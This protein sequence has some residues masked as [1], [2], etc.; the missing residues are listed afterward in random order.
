MLD[1]GGLVA[2]VFPGVNELGEAG[3]AMDALKVMMQLLR[4]ADA[5]T[6]PSDVGGG[7]SGAGGGAGASEEPV[8]VVEDVERV[9]RVH[10]M[11]GVDH[12]WDKHGWIRFPRAESTRLMTC[13]AGHK[14]ERRD[15]FTFHTNAANL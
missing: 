11:P 2:A 4:V 12:H 15:I 7:G 3:V 9:R 6:P 1:L 5:W 14:K 10:N 8:E 13:K